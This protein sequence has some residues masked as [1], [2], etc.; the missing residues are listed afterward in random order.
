M[1]YTD[2][3]TTLVIVFIYLISSLSHLPELKNEKSR[4]QSLNLLW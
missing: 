4:H 3:I 2:D 1:A